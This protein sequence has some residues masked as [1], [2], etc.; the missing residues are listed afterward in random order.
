LAL[1]KPNVKKMESRKDVEGLL[2]VY[3][4]SRYDQDLRADIQYALIRIGEPTVKPLVEWVVRFPDPLHEDNGNFDHW[5]LYWGATEIIQGMPKSQL[6]PLIP[7]IRSR[8]L[9]VRRKA[10]SLAADAKYQQASSALIDALFEPDVQAAAALALIEI[11]DKNA[12]DGLLHVIKTGD[13]VSRENAA[14]ALGK[15][16]M[17]EH[18]PVLLG[19][20]G[21]EAP[22]PRVSALEWLGKT[23]DTTFL[24]AILNMLDD[25][26]ASVRAAAIEA[27]GRLEGREYFDVLARMV[28]DPDKDVRKRVAE[29][30]GRL[31]LKKAA[32][33]LERAANYTV[34]RHIDV[35][36]KSINKIFSHMSPIMILI[37]VL[38]TVYLIFII[39]NLLRWSMGEFSS[40]AY[41]NY[42][43]KFFMVFPTLFLL[44]LYLNYYV[45]FVLPRF[46]VDIVFPKLD[47]EDEVMLHTLKSGLEK[48]FN[49]Q[50]VGEFLQEIEILVKIKDEK[51]ERVSI[52]P[53]SYIERTGV[54]ISKFNR[55]S[56]SDRHKILEAV[57]EAA[58]QSFLTPVSDE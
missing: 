43:I 54:R 49:V 1:F 2:R 25:K 48:C 55:F 4:N 17:K 34:E 45:W 46:N 20:L 36:R 29:A 5:F 51:I 15:F 26:D 9:K 32:L 6:G 52:E 30:L 33:T 8:D 58:I 7:L 47:F 24:P 12:I 35:E 42:S 13:K 19:L 37:A 40:N 11:Q 22:G 10:M 56:E 50:I 41:I 57:K 23:G 27:I 21:D 53:Y 31:D 16:Q 28:D 3:K 14:Y 39:E 44:N 18:L 38:M